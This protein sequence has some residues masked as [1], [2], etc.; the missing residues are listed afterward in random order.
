MAA[1]S[2]RTPAHIDADAAATALPRVLMLCYFFP[3]IS[4]SG[5]HR[6]VNFAR[7]L[8]RFGWQPVVL[9]V[10]QSK[11]PWEATGESVPENLTIVRSPE[12]NLTG[13]LRLMTRCVNGIR[14]A[15]RLPRLTN[16]IFKWC[17]PDPQLAWLTTIPGIKWAQS[18]SCL[19]VSC[20]PFSS[21]LSGCLIK[22]VTGRPLVV[23][24]RDAWSLNAYQVRTAL[25][26]RLVRTMES[27]VVRCCDA[28][29]VNTP[30]TERLYRR[31]YP[32][33]APK[34]TCIPNGFDRL[35][36]PR[37]EERPDHFVIMH[38]GDFYRSRTPDRL[39]HALARIGA[40]DI[41]FV[42]VGPSF[43]S[44]ARFKSSVRMRVVERIPRDAALALMRRASLLYLCQGF[45]AHVSEYTAVAAKTYEYLATGLP[46]LADCPRGDNADLVERFA[47]HSYVVTDQSIDAIEAAVRRAYERRHAV[48]PAVLPEFV[49]RFGREV[50]ASQLADILRRV[51]APAGTRIVPAVTDIP[52]ARVR[53]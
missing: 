24:F 15:L 6:S 25:Q 11:I 43:E 13:L 51:A 36:L 14:R 12:W 48:E 9:T 7:L 31:Q 39:L 10:R 30:G 52:G 35:N 33:Q 44:Y 26:Q 29:I 46:I 2:I 19:Y 4:S 40:P 28:L 41:E 27:L 1:S 5:T 53:R 8:P 42:Q 16:Q 32:A 37:R 50:Q 49:A 23:D 17:L 22:R 47:S 20:S 34:I 45:E 18:C 38:V 3:P 21:A